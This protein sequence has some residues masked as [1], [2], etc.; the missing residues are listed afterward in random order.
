MARLVEKIKPPKLVRRCIWVNQSVAPDKGQLLA[1]AVV[2]GIEGDRLIELLEARG[3]ITC[4]W[5]RESQSEVLIADKFVQ[6]IC[7]PGTF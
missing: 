1:N 5:V 4:T 3:L 7:P 6:G 2:S